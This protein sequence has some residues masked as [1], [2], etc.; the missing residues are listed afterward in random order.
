MGHLVARTFIA[1]RAFFIFMQCVRACALPRGPL[2]DEKI[3]A[4]R[5]ISVMR[6]TTIGYRS[7]PANKVGKLSVRRKGVD[8]SR[9]EWG[10]SSV[11]AEP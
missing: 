3:P 4:W 5:A 6:I 11:A 2:I 9:P 10:R 7:L 8:A 1:A